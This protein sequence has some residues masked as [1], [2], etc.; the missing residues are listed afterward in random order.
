MSINVGFRDV[1][2]DRD[3]AEIRRMLAPRAAVAA[4]GLNRLRST[5]SQI[6]WAAVMWIC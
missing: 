2:G 6:A 3:C 5:I 4:H 1:R